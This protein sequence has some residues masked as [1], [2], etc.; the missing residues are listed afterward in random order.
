MTPGAL[1]EAA[2]CG[3]G[4]RPWEGTSRYSIRRTELFEAAGVRTAE[5]TGRTEHRPFQIGPE[6]ADL[7]RMVAQSRQNIAPFRSRRWRGW[8]CVSHPSTTAPR[9]FRGT[10]AVDEAWK[11]HDR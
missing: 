5:A 4:R 9:F 1:F 7:R 10:G 8:S 3:P 2:A 11:T 6:M